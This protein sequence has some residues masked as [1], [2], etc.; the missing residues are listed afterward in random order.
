MIARRVT[1]PIR[2][3]SLV[4]L[5]LAVAIGVAVAA[6]QTGLPFGGPAVLGVG[7]PAVQAQV[8][9]PTLEPAKSAARLPLPVVAEPIP[10][11]APTTVRVSVEAKEVIAAIDDGV[12]FEFWTFGGTVPGPM[13]R[14]LQGDTV[15]LTF[16]NAAESRI[17]AMSFCEPRS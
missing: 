7:Q 10:S 4:G 17:V 15:E 11:R 9:L 2:R 16:K 13:I 1:P 14:V 8:T 12:S 5:V 3:T 6:C